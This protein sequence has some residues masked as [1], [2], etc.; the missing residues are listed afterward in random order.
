MQGIEE[1]FRRKLAGLRRLP[2]EARAHALRAAQADR[3]MAV[4]L[5]RDRRDRARRS[6]LAQRRQT[7]TPR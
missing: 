5:L 7:P 6:R 2:R 4:R 3:Q 1:E